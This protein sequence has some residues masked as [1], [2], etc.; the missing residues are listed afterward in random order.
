M[1]TQRMN[2]S[3]KVLNGKKCG[4]TV[5]LVIYF[6]V[7]LVSAEDYWERRGGGRTTQRLN[8]LK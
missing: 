6:S 1:R 3:V 4:R 7:E 2:E 8:N 5:L